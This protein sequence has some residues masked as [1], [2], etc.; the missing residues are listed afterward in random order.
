MS[1][2]VKFRP[3]AI[4]IPGSRAFS[5]RIKSLELDLR[6]FL[7]LLLQVMRNLI[8]G[9]TWII[10]GVTLSHTLNGPALFSLITF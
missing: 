9:V 10:Q 6:L 1:I 4:G 8:Q 7:L 5:L 2:A 3:W